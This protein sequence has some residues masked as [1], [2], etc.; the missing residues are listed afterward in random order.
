MG[1][2]SLSRGPIAGRRDFS[3]NKEGKG[4]QRKI[5]VPFTLGCLL[6]STGKGPGDA[7]P[8]GDSE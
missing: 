7:G 4:P 6:L 3:R 1:Q 2:K 5:K 8:V